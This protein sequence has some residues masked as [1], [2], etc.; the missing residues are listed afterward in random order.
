ML[1]PH[2]LHCA[3]EFHGRKELFSSTMTVLKSTIWAMCDH[4]KEAPPTANSYVISKKDPPS[5]IPTYLFVPA[6]SSIHPLP[7]TNGSSPR[8]LLSRA[9]FLFITTLQ[10]SRSSCHI[11]QSGDSICRRVETSSLQR[12]HVHLTRLSSHRDND[13]S[14]ERPLLRRPKTA[15]IQSAQA[16]KNHFHH[17]ALRTTEQ[18]IHDDAVRRSDCARSRPD[19]RRDCQRTRHGGWCCFFLMFLDV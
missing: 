1:P 5:T 13:S 17:S 10:S 3:M 15:T 14:P 2:K 8:T 11:S 7:T 9:S 12:P 19:I 18:V 6:Y 4:G 16:M